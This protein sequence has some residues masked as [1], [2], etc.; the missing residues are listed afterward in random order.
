MEFV[1]YIHTFPNGKKYVG[2]SKNIQCRFRNGRGY[3]KQPIMWSAIKKFGWE[4]VNTEIVFEGLSEQAAKQAEIE[5]ISRFKT[6][7]RAYGYNQTLGGEGANGRPVSEKNK[8]AIGERMSKVHK[9]VP[10]S[11]EHKQK[12][13]ASL[14]GRP[15][16][17]SEDGHRRIIQSNMTRSCSIETREKM[18]RNTKAAMAQKNMGEYLSEKWQAEKEIRKAKLRITMYN[19][20]GVIPTKYDLRDD[21]LLLCLD[22]NNYSELFSEMEDVSL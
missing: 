4:N 11:E 12:I 17:Y 8:R 3:E 22:K 6:A 20:Y 1:V 9:G 14:K 5:L 15:K 16:E 13:S 7:D 10:L 2:I 18:S 19:R 21:V